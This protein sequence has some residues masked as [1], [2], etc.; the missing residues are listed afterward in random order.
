M[1]FSRIYEA[2][3]KTD[4]SLAKKFTEKFW[5]DDHWGLGALKDLK[6]FPEHLD[7]E[8]VEPYAVGVDFI[9]FAGGGDWQAT[10]FF[11]VTLDNGELKVVPFERHDKQDDA[12]QLLN[13]LKDF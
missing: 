4:P 1:K 13:A 12:Q 11:D 5:L 9:C 7:L 2:A 8:N 10:T 3:S 6:G